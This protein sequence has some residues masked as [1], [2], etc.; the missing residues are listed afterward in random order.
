MHCATS[1]IDEKKILKQMKFLEGSRL[2][3]ALCFQVLIHIL[4]C[5][6]LET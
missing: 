6:F 1:G 2:P 4:E 3:V 5:V